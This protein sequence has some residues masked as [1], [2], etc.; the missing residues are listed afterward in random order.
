M[1]DCNF[2]KGHRPQTWVPGSD[3]SMDDCNLQAC[4]KSS[5]VASSDSSMDDCNVS[6]AQLAVLNKKFR[7]LYGRL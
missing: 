1:D 5:H 6:R 2:K 7:F 4:R 3:S